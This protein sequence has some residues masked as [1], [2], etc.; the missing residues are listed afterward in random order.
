MMGWEDAEEG[1]NT[2]VMRL[3]EQKR[4]GLKVRRGKFKL[5]NLVNQIT[6]DTDLFICKMRKITGVI[7]WAWILEQDCLGVN[8]SSATYYFVSLDT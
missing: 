5:C 2:R 7:P 8:P 4:P 6:S 1:T 3:L